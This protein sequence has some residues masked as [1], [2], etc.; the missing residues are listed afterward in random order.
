MFVSVTKQLKRALNAMKSVLMVAVTV[1]G[2][3]DP[4]LRSY[5]REGEQLDSIGMILLTLVR[6]IEDDH[7]Q[8][9]DQETKHRATLRKL[10]LLRMRRE[11]EQGGLYAK[12]LR[13]RKRFEDAFGQGTAPVYL[14]LEPRL[15]DVEPLVL[16]RHARET[17]GILTDPTF[18]TPEPDVEG[19]WD[20]PL[21]YADQIREALG[22]F[23]MTIDEIEAQKKVV[24]V[25]LKAKTEMLDELKDRLKWSIR[26]FEA[27][28]QLAGEG[29]H[30]D[31][32][33][34]TVNARPPTEENDEKSKDGDE[35]SKDG[36]EESKGDDRPQPAAAAPETSQP[37]A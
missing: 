30:A 25:A 3:L 31:R 18:S 5:L 10:K 34:L 17:V 28:Y 14:G 35:K 9:E 32:L 7:D 23:Q 15:G 4:K 29:F 8:L 12:M 13:I 37:E 22:P 21:K 16:R 26:L 19:V 1:A 27:I 24:D 20:N 33:R 11:E 36:D 2:K 6:W